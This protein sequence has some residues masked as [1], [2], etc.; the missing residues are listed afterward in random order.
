M[1]PLAE[2]FITKMNMKIY[3]ESLVNIRRIWINLEVSKINAW[4]AYVD[5]K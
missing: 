2:E 3:K 5:G 4:K 1:K